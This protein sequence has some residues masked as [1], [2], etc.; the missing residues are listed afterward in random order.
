MGTDLPT[1]VT[2]GAAAAFALAL[3]ARTADRHRRVTR[4][5]LRAVAAAEAA[6]RAAAEVEN[7][8]ENKDAPAPPPVAGRVGPPG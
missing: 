6:R 5:A 3:L 7:G 4:D 8:V 2:A 1:L